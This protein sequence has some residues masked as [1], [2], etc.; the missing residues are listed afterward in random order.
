MEAGAS[1]TRGVWGDALNA[2]AELDAAL[3]EGVLHGQ[4]I[5]IDVS[6]QEKMSSLVG[7]RV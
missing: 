5:A 2:E 4:R 6:Y 1:E 3:A 7:T